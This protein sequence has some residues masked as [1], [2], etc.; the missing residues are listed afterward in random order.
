MIEKR[1]DTKRFFLAILT[2]VLLASLLPHASAQG[3]ELHVG[4]GQEFSTIQLAIDEADDYDIIIV[5]DGTYNE[6]VNVDKPLTIRSVNGF[7]VTTVQALASGD[8]VFD[9]S[10]DYVKIEGFTIKG[11]TGTDKAGIYLSSGVDHCNISAN[12][13]TGNYYGI[14]LVSSGY[15]TIINNNASSNT[16]YG[17][18][19]DSSNDNDL[20]NNIA[21][22]SGYGI[23]LSS[24][25]SNTLTNNTVNSN[26]Y[27][28]GI[29]GMAST[30]LLRAITI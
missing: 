12:K 28:G 9:V 10:C 18:Y 7:S 26:K 15:N 30:C 19:L 14:Y 4:P 20:K 3:A 25:N 22:L 27:G 5:H 29:L 1:E 2:A 21:N 17:I 11:A 13:P 24:S 6:N 16:K 23:C 8:H